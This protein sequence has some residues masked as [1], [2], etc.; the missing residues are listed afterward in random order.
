MAAASEI[1]SAAFAGWRKLATLLLTLAAVGLPVNDLG[2]YALLLVAAI[3]IFGGEVSARASA[4]A[5]AVAIVA[6]AVAGQFVLAPPRIEEGYNAFL[7]SPAL[8]RELPAEVYRRLAS[9]FDPQYL[10]AIRCRPGSVGC[11]QDG[12]FPDSAFAFS[13]DGIF[14]KSRLSRSV[15]EAGAAR[16]GT[17]L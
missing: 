1:A 4:W 16:G 3:V 8:E 14:H 13:A 10:P 7:P 12:G 11:W 9:E 17:L 2:T 5:V 15:T 6:I